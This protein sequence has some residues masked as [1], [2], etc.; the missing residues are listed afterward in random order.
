MIRIKK[1]REEG[2]NVSRDNERESVEDGGNPR[3]CPFRETKM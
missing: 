3:Q 2:E 1:E